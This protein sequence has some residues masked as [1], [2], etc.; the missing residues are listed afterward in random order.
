MLAAVHRDLTVCQDSIMRTDF[1]KEHSNLTF[2][3]IACI[4]LFMSVNV[5]EMC[6]KGND[7]FKK[8]KQYRDIFNLT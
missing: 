6:M 2:S 4:I 5:R 1:S 8:S 3:V 7:Y